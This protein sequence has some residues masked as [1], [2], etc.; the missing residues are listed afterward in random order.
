MPRHIQQILVLLKT[1]GFTH[2]IQ[3]FGYVGILVWFITFDQFT[4]FPEEISLLVVGYL[5]AHHIFN[6]VIAGLFSLAGF[7]AVDTAY[8]FLSKK[9]SGFIKK[10]TKGSSALMQSLKEKL[11]TNLPKSL[12]IICFIPRM[13]MFAPILAGSL[14]LP[15]KKFLLFDAMALLVFTSL[16][17]ALGV[18]FHRTLSRV[19]QKAQGLQ[20]IIFAGAVIVIAGII[21]ILV[22]RRKN[23]RHEVK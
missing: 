11:K 16:Y 2:F 6:P 8:F 7:L 17:L 14:R 9:G 19:I 4:P 22:S 20:N 15:F 3:H 13:R 12:L 1:P 21:M 18:I 5:S 23:Q 10:R